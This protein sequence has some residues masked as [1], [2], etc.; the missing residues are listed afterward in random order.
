MLVKSS[1]WGLACKKQLA[2]MVKSS[3]W[4]SAQKHKF[5]NRDQI[6]LTQA[7]LSYTHKSKVIDIF[8][9]LCFNIFPCPLRSRGSTGRSSLSPGGNEAF[10]SVRAG[11]LIACRTL[12]L[13]W[14]AA[15]LQIFWVLE[16][17]KNSLM[18]ALPA[19]Q[20]FM[21]RVRTFRRHIKMIDYG[22]PTEK[23]TWLY[24]GI[25]GLMFCSHVLELKYSS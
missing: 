11:N 15:A 20:A 23:P 7:C 8:V 19:F 24:S 14:V 22:G 17:P 6:L 18:E 5:G 3:I 13:L 21:K 25:W 1:V 4:G 16:Q 10:E 12:V 9:H 2:K